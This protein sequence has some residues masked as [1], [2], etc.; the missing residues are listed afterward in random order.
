MTAP[1]ILAK[2]IR[3]R[4]QAD[5]ARASADILSSESPRTWTGNDT[6]FEIGV[7]IGA[8]LVDLSNFASLTLTIEK[9]DRSAKKVEQTLAAAALTF[10]PDL[11]AWTAGTAQ[12]ATFRFVGSDM[13][14]LSSGIEESFFLVLWGLTADSPAR[15]IT[16]GWA[17]FV[18]EKDGTAS[19]TPTPAPTDDYYTQ[20]QSDAR[21]LLNNDATKGWRFTGEHLQFQFPDGQWRA[22]IP[23]IQNGQPT[24]TWG[25]PT[26]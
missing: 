11:T 3:L 2:R 21:Y 20:T 7:F 4:I 22:L 15:E 23:A 17:T 14:F 24:H 6:Q 1:T 16:L 5:K 19:A 25:D 18:L 10:L 9:L 8:A 12:H 13:E 26:A